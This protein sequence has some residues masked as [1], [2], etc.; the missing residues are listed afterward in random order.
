[1][2]TGDGKR[3]KEEATAQFSE[4]NA[5]PPSHDP[6]AEYGTRD[7][8]RSRDEIT[9][10]SE[11]IVW[12]YASR[13]QM[14]GFRLISFSPVV[15]LSLR[16]SCPQASHGEWATL[17]NHDHMST[18]RTKCQRTILIVSQW[19][20]ET[21]FGQHR[22]CHSLNLRHFPSFAAVDE[23]RM[24]RDSCCSCLVE[25]RIYFNSCGKKLHLVYFAGESEQERM[26]LRVST[27]NY[28]SVNFLRP[29]HKHIHRIR[30]LERFLLLNM[31]KI[32]SSYR[33]W[34]SWSYS[35]WIRKVFC[36]IWLSSAYAPPSL[37]N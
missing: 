30:F 4:R 31:C 37:V 15:M 3:D 29:Y 20:T 32:H 11:T 2:S 23:R 6:R 26:R 19:A 9:G 35:Q 22:S 17:I 21:L 10:R 7:V 34:K 36:V 13:I 16:N 12:V 27:A 24:K 25:V 33:V 18:P 8:V 1:M 28:F 5:L 14:W